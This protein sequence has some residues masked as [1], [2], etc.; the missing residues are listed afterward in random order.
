MDRRNPLP[1]QTTNL[2]SVSENGS[3]TMESPA[4]GREMRSFL[5]AKLRHPLVHTWEFWHEKPAVGGNVT[6]PS[7][8]PSGPGFN[9]TPQSE[10]QFAPRLTHMLSISDIRGFWSLY[11]NFDFAALPQRSSVHLFHAT[12]KP[13]WED[14]RNV[15]GGAWTFRV[16]KAAATDFWREICCLAIGETLQEAI[17]TDRTTFK[18]DICGVSFRPRFASVLV[19]I[20]NRDGDH[21]EGVQRL[22]ETVLRSMPDHLRPKEG[23]YYYKKHSEHEGFDAGAAKKN[24]EL[25]KTQPEKEASRVKHERVKSKEQ[26]DEEVQNIAKI[27]RESHITETSTPVDGPTD[28]T[29]KPEG[30][31]K[32][33]DKV[34]GAGTAA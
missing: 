5:Q 20:W 12:V 21:T 23:S 8:N 7:T 10:E 3:N 13:L 34:E 16:P 30:E 31:T 11:N 2:P 32:N 14:P 22:A 6:S 26:M 15:R 28:G 4:R 25:K 9:P 19:T 18:D 17:K 1:L 33:E 29:E 24:E 27:I